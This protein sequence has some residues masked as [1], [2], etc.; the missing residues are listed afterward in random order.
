[1]DT[2][3]LI[4]VAGTGVTIVVKSLLLLL[5]KPEDLIDDK[6]V[7]EMIDK[8]SCDVKDETVYQ[9]IRSFISFLYD[10]KFDSSIFSNIEAR[11][12]FSELENLRQKILTLYAEDV[13]VI[14]KS[15]EYSKV[16]DIY[17][18]LESMILQLMRLRMVI[19]PEFQFSKNVHP[20]TQ[21]AYM[22]AKGFW[23]EDDGKRVRCITKSLGRMDDYKNGKNDPKA[24]EK[25]RERLR[26]ALYEK[27]KEIYP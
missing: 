2:I 1:M 8:Y 21:I 13:N 25:A 7:K 23:L 4:S 15:L 16:Y 11:L 12:L 3:E 17:A 10:D 6:Y 20:K 18:K 24:T 19:Q 14:A 27:Y 26:E 5:V 9:H 22:A